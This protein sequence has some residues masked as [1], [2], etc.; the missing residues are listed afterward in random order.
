MVVSLNL[1]DK[2]DTRL[3][4]IAEVIAAELGKSPNRSLAARELIDTWDVNAW[5]KARRAR[6]LAQAREL[7]QSAA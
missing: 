2:Y 6:L 1:G 3:D 4:E 5:R 7:N